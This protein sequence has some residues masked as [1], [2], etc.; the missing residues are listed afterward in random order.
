MLAVLFSLPSDIKQALLRGD[1][2]A[3]T[4]GPNAHLGHL[5]PRTPGRLEK[6]LYGSGKPWI[7]VLHLVNT[8]YD[9]PDFETMRRMLGYAK[10]YTDKVVP[11][12]GG[13]RPVRIIKSQN[14]TATP[15]NLA[16]VMRI[17][18]AKLTATNRLFATALDAKA[19]NEA[20]QAGQ[21]TV[22]CLYITSEGQLE[23]IKQACDIMEARMEDLKQNG[24]D[25]KSPRPLPSTIASCGWTSDAGNRRN[26][27]YRH[28]SI[29]GKIRIWDAISLAFRHD[30]LSWQCLFMPWHED[31]VSMS[32][33][34]GHVLAGT[35][36]VQG[37]MNGEAAGI[38][39]ASKVSI[40]SLQYKE[41][42]RKLLNTSHWVDNRDGTDTRNTH[43]QEN[44]AS[45]KRY[46]QAKKSIKDQSI[47]VEDARS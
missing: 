5:V 36:V 28:S 35:Y 44:T 9:N 25:P 8:R 10:A 17:D 29:N 40:A 38:S 37:G 6:L 31:A 24:W 1:L 21:T 18:R 3:L 26:E 46:F 16:R 13:G 22:P 30:G 12:P 20:L 33:H 27:Y 15:G 32:E 43:V 42:E 4:A 11:A 45:L 23:G 47:A 34:I 19:L 2:P 7:Y 14:Y 39:V 41:Q